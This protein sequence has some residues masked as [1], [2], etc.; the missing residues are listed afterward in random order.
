MASVMSPELEAAL[1]ELEAFYPRFEAAIAE[2]DAEAVADLVADRGAA[3]AAVAQL[4][5][6]EPDAALAVRERIHDGERALQEGLRAL[7]QQVFDAL[8]AHRRRARAVT[9]YASSS[10]S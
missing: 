3:V 7:H 5:A 9:R 1:S 2:A 4:T 10:S 6:A 8:L